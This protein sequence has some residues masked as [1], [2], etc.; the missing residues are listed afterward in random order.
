MSNK[1]VCISHT[2]HAVDLS[3]LIEARPSEQYFPWKWVTVDK[4]K[5]FQNWILR[6][7]LLNMIESCENIKENRL[8]SLYFYIFQSL[9]KDLKFSAFYRSIHLVVVH[10]NTKKMNM[11][12]QHEIRNFKIH[13]TLK[14]KGTNSKGS[15]AQTQNLKM[16]WINFVFGVSWAGT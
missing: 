2:M 10:P 5:Y 6:K 1:F 14:F 16:C 4:K 13:W 7:Y 12:N 15:R 3:F 9:L 11:R 8:Y